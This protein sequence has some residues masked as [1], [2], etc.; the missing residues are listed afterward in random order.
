MEVPPSRDEGTCLVEPGRESECR[1]GHLRPVASVQVELVLGVRRVR[2]V[3]PALA[4]AVALLGEPVDAQFVDLGH[5]QREHQPGQLLVLVDA[6]TA[7]GAD[8]RAEHG[9]VAPGEVAIA[10]A[11]APV[12]D[13]LTVGV[14]AT[15]P[16]RG[17][18]LADRIGQAL[19]RPLRV[20]VEDDGEDAGLDAVVVVAR[21][22]R[23]ENDLSE[24]GV[25]LDPA[26][27]DPALDQL[28]TLLGGTDDGLSEDLIVH[29]VTPRIATFL[30]VDLGIR[31]T[32]HDSS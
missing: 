8:R 4:A 21:P 31:S 13:E 22:G 19:A 3:E 5:H 15:V 28:L 29:R 1:N 11:E 10:E 25:G 17:V 20:S 12:R 30:Q 27:R 7:A 6:Q 9:V 32:G 24:H 26:T 23:V 2:E 18:R 14:V 16:I